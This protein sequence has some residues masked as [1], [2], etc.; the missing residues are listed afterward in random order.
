M[1]RSGIVPQRMAML[2]LVGGPLILRDGALAAAT[3]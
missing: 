1:Y 2:G 3:A